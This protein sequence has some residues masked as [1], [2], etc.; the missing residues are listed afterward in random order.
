ME[1]DETQK[2]NANEKIQNKILHYL[3]FVVTWKW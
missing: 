3:A 2:K 1:S